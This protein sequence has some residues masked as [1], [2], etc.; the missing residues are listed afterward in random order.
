MFYTAY[1]RTTKMLLCDQ[2]PTDL[3]NI[4]LLYVKEMEKPQRREELKLIPIWHKIRKTELAGAVPL[5]IV[6]VHLLLTQGLSHS[7]GESP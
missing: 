2:I 5:P 4:V 1:T 3:A 6:K 7:N